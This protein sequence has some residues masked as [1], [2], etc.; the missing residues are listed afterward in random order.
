MRA[1][2]GALLADLRIGAI[3]T[4]MLAGSAA[5]TAVV[6]VLRTLKVPLVVDPVLVSTGGTRLLP[7][8]SITL[9]RR[10]LIPLATVL[11]PNIPEA[12]VLLGRRLRRPADI[13]HAARD[14]LEFGSDA[15]LL[16][17]GHLGGGVVR[18]VLA[19]AQST[20][21]FAHARLPARLRGTGCCLS[22][23]LAAGLARDM[24]LLDAVRAAER[25]VH[26][27]IRNA[28]RL[29]RGDRHALDPLPQPL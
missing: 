5:I 22:A 25:F 21:E 7:A 4:G 2:L 9:L 16:K 27:A 12:E 18:D 24:D 13:A 1:Q 14:L 3:K 8:R 26:R 19:D 11:T 6:D 28:Y 17:G 29:G 23:A 20:V 15:V 10:R